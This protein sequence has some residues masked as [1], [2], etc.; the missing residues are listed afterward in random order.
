VTG[1]GRAV[2]AA[3]I[4]ALTLGGAATAAAH[5]E[6]AAPVDNVDQGATSLNT[7]LVAS[8]DGLTTALFFQPAA[9][10]P[11]PGSPYMVR[12]APATA[13]WTA[14]AAVT[15]PPGSP[16]T[17][18]RPALAAGA[19]GDA[20]GVFN[21]FDP[22][23]RTV[24]QAT[25]WPADAV[26]P[27]AAV[28]ALCGTGAACE[29]NQPQVAV[30]GAG[31]GYAVSIQG[32]TNIVLAKRD[33]VTGTWG[34]AE[35]VATGSEPR[36][37]VSPAGDVLV[38]YNRNDT[39][40][41]G[42]T[43]RRLYAKRRLASESSFGPELQVTGPNAT[44]LAGHAAVMD[45]FGNATILFPED[46]LPPTGG[47]PAAPVIMA[48]RW[49]ESDAVPEG[50]QPI[51][52]QPEGQA[53]F[54]VGAA[55]PSGR[56]TAA[57]STFTGHSEILSSELAGGGWTDAQHVSPEGGN[58]NSSSPQVAVD[59]AGTATVVYVDQAS[60]QGGD[61]DV[62]VSRRPTD[63][64]WSEPHSLRMAGGGAG[65]V[66]GAARV[67]AGRAGQAD[68]I[69]VQQQ[70]GVSRL[71]ASRFDH[72]G[73]P[74]PKSAS[75]VTVSLV[76]AY[77][78][79]TAPNRVHG[80]PL[81]FDSCNP[82]AQ[83]SS[84]LTVGSPDANGQ[85]SNSAGYVRFGVV[86]GDPDTP[87]DEADVKVSVSLTDVRNQGDLSD[88]TGE[89]DAVSTVRITDREGDEPSTIED[90][91]F[92]TSVPCVATGGPAGATCSV[93][94]TFDAIVPGSAA[95]RTRAVWQLGQ[96]QVF[97]GGA[98]GDAGTDPNTLFAVQGVF[99]P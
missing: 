56:V 81:A 51:P 49:V 39:S 7:A 5:W 10:G 74:R 96:V 82:P 25:S 23:N 45:N 88:Y 26:A 11:Q 27:D 90:M 69:F 37:A 64:T 14:P 84:F 35:T 4:V 19:D 20:L 86:P 54:V 95:E 2:V 13:A 8:P 22:A 67:A 71:V 92:G 57:W 68:V 21:Y 85:P 98:D 87:A 78:Q 65:A 80:P 30:D 55:D 16:N 34:P 73:Y 38:V 9:G 63:G 48:A 66:Q 44:E 1:W 31:D 93:D 29:P 40:T 52:G 94:T 50:R 79:C 99:V 15:T 62:K 42:L 97:D 91:A 36:L 33:G 43:V 3:A 47:G 59:S 76:P 17:F 89:L 12:R 6:T 70:L 41:P 72:S 28:P 24:V 61:V 75:P 32:V 77:T 83:R 60:P 58:R 46:S 53:R 18:A